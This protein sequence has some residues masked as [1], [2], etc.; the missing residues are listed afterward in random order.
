VPGFDDSLRREL[1]RLAEPGDPSGAFERVLE[2]KIRRRIARKLQVAALVVVVVAG[3]IGGTFGL[4]WVFRGRPASERPGASLPGNRK[5]AFASDR[6]GNNEIYVMNPDGTESARLTDDPAYDSSPAWS[7]DGS[8]I[9]FARDAG[10]AEGPPDSDLYVMN[11]DGEDPRNLTNNALGVSTAVAYAAWSP[12]GAFIAFQQQLLA[13]QTTEIYLINPDG[14]GLKQLTHDPMSASSPVWSP[15]GL[16]LA[17][18]SDDGLSVMNADGTERITLLQRNLD[19]LIPRAWSPDGST[20]AFVRIL[21]GPTEADVST[22]IYM[23]DADGSNERR[24]TADHASQDPAWSPDGT[25]I[26]FSSNR[27]GNSEIY[28]MNPDGTGIVRLTDDPGADTNP[29][30]QPLGSEEPTPSQTPTETPSPSPT[31]SEDCSTLE[32]SLTGDF[33]GDDVPDIATVGPSDCFEIFQ[34]TDFAVHIEWKPSGEGIIALLP[35]CQSACGAF[36][37]A[38]LNADGIDEL[39]IL[40]DVG[41]STQF[42]EVYELWHQNGEA[43]FEGPALVIEPGAPGFPADEPARFAIGGSVTHQDFMTCRNVESGAPEVI[44]TSGELSQDQTKWNVHETV[45]QFAR[46]LEPPFGTFTVVSTRD[47]T[48]AF[49]PTGETR[50][51]PPG[52][53]CWGE[54]I[55]VP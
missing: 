15:D 44:A 16:R 43:D 54:T 39:V 30:W 45:F 29:A 17:F 8:R 6:D 49:D 7:P 25:K 26:A 23:V 33:E 52:V 38:D 2:R 36:T 24:L 34:H 4:A 13:T 9:T 32:T 12:D 31:P 40:V 28:T 3:T 55:S 22:D 51:E 18:F 53:S 35:E 21:V 10:G 5:I 37:A 20:I 48:V 11:L 46:I 1:A 19:Y 50:L 42:V 41:A 14:S 47:Y 27:N